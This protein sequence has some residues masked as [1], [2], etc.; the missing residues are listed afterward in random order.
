MKIL[1]KQEILSA[2]DTKTIEV[3]VPE[4]GGAVR[5]TTMSGSSRDLYEQSLAKAMDKGNSF[6]NLRATFLAFCLVDEEGGLLF[7]PADIESL[8][9][10]SG[11][12]LDLVF[13]EASR[14]NRT[15]F[16]GS[17]EAAKN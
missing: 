13:R 10:K 4:W 17:E 2:D 16:A 7:S 9:K 14:L 11:L 15:G 1:S 5:I 12:A 3:E 8:G 6:S